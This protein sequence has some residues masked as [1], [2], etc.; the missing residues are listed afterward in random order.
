MKHLERVAVQYRQQVMDRTGSVNAQAFTE[1]A[2]DGRVTGPNASRPRVV[3]IQGSDLIDILEKKGQGGRLPA[4]RRDD[5]SHGWRLPTLSKDDPLESGRQP[6]VDT[7][8][9]TMPPKQEPG[10]EEK[11]LMAKINMTVWEND[12]TV[13]DKY[14]GKAKRFANLRTQ[15]PVMCTGM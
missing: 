14:R 11:Q 2:A 10:E 7:P 1:G 5:A 3:P 9:P 15:A 12:Q 4:V 8:T 13:V 6:A